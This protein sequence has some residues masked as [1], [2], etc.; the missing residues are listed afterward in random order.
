M[1]SDVGWLDWWVLYNIVLLVSSVLHPRREI[2][3][4]SSVYLSVGISYSVMRESL[5]LD[6]YMVG[7]LLESIL[8]ISFYK[9]LS[10]ARIRVSLVISSVVLVILSLHQWLILH[11]LYNIDFFRGLYLSPEVFEFLNK[12]SLEF[13]L[14]LVWLNYPLKLAADKR[15]SLDSFNFILCT[16]AGLV[17]MNYLFSI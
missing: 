1:V 14:A 8:A 16:A 3:L 2:R 4:L 9:I 12:I 10:N 11:F 17:L 13:Y 7:V 5:G 15:L 6:Y